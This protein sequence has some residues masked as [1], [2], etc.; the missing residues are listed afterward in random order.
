M[1]FF[2]IHRG[3]KGFTIADMMEDNLKNIGNDRAAS[4]RS[5]GRLLAIRRYQNGRGH[6]TQHAFSWRHR[7]YVITNESKLIRY[8]RLSGKIIHFIVQEVSIH[9]LPASKES[10]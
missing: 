4:R 3:L 1:K 10:I 5:E 2:V 6:T 7:I 8:P 9:P